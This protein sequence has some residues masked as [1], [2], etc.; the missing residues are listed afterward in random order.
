MV[1]ISF[2]E[3]AKA[4]FSAAPLKGAGPN[5]APAI[6]WQKLWPT[7]KNVVVN[8]FM[9]LVG[10]GVMPE[11]WKT[12]R[13]IPLRKPQKP[14]YTKS[15]AYCPIS[16]LATLGKM[17]ESI[18]AQ[19]LAFLAD[20][21]SFL[22]YNHFRG[23]KQKTTVDALL[24]LQDKIYQAWKEKKVLSLIT[25]DV[26]GAFSS[27]AIDVLIQRLQKRRISEQMMA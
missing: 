12:G 4:V 24:V 19:R 18:M 13:I 5:S 17:L 15:G 27:V 22:L 23:L 2:N 7:I 11:Q 14:D 25:F 1:P 20:K 9:A 6:V 21:Y 26:K 3:V 16:L 10:L 8:L